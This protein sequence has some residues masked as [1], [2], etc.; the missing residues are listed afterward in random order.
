MCPHKSW[1]DKC[2][3]AEQ[4]ESNKLANQKKSDGQ[5]TCLMSKKLGILPRNAQC[6]KRQERKPKVQLEDA[7][8]AMRR[9]ISLM[10]VHTSKTSI[11]Q[12]KAAYAMLVEER[13]I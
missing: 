12:T 2:A 7:M 11:E 10:D 1:A 6:T 3:A 5:N 13:G 4:K 8:G 9:A